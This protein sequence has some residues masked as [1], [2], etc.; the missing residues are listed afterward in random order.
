[1]AGPAPF[2]FT[3]KGVGGNLKWLAK[4]QVGYQGEQQGVFHRSDKF[5]SE[6][7]G[8]LSAHTANRL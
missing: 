1:L 4:R 3:L 6:G 7:H 8:L 5:M 2:D